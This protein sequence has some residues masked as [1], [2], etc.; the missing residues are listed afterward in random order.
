M[1][2]PQISEKL[3]EFLEESFPQKSVR[4]SDTTNEIMFRAGQRHVVEWLRDQ[5]TRRQQEDPHNV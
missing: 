3:V 5:L 1:N 4:P 2:T